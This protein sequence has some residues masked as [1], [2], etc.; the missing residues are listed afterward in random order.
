MS[1]VMA[2]TRRLYFHVIFSLLLTALLM[3]K[4]IIVSLSTLFV[5]YFGRRGK[6][7]GKKCGKPFFP[8]ICH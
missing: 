7:T 8:I 1:E 2:A 4:G 6:H 5:E 3:K